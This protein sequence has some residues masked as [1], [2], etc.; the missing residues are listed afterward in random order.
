MIIEEDQ[1]MTVT[2]IPASPEQIGNEPDE[3]VVNSQTVQEKLPIED[4][5]TANQKV[6]TIN[7]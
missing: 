5:S 4:V 2:E 3:L 6:S 1:A 7:T